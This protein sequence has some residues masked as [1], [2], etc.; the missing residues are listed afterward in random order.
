MDVA[1]ERGLECPSYSIKYFSRTIAN[2]DPKDD[3]DLVLTHSD[4]STGKQISELLYFDPYA[5]L[6]SD[7]ITQL[8]A[9]EN[10]KNLLSISFITKLASRMY[11][12]S[13]V[14]ELVLNPDPSI[15]SEK[16]KDQA[17][18]PGEK[19]RQQLRCKH[20]FEAWVK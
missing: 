15:L 4:G 3:P 16:Y 10:A 20:I 11:P 9:K 17:H 6:T 8:F 7:L 2:R 1:P 5:V 13:D 14:L 12:F 18:S 19:S